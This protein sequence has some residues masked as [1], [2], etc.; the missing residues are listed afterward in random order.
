V[1]SDKAS[2]PNLSKKARKV[3][4]AD[5]AQENGLRVAKELGCQFHL[6]DVT[7]EDDWEALLKKVLDTQCRLD[8]VINNAG[9]T[10][11]NKVWLLGPLYRAQSTD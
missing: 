5:L 11:I 2:R 10:Y 4:I 6:S 3:I 7:K 1:D 9:G 8:I